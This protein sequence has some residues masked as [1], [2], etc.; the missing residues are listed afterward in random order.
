MLLIL[1]PSD[2]LW[3]AHAILRQAATEELPPPITRHVVEA[4][5]SIHLDLAF[6]YKGERHL[7]WGIISELDRGEVE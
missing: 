3:F 4:F 1:H 7:E 6:I 5:V 2:S